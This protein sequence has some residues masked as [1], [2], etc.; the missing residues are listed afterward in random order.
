MTK[1]VGIFALL[2]LSACTRTEPVVPTP[3][4]TNV[5]D[6]DTHTDAPVVLP[7]TDAPVADTVVVP[8]P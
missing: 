6:T 7:H 8:A 4:E 2:S 1:F 3:V 5:V